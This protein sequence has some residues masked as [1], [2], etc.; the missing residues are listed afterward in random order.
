MTTPRPYT[1]PYLAGIGLGLVLL[2]A[3]VVA[4]RGLGATGAFATA[5][6][7]GVAAAAPEH[8]AA[9]SAYASYSGRAGAAFTGEWLVWQI[10][11]VLLGG[12]LSALA[13]GR[14]RVAV[15]RGSGIQPRGRM[16][17]AFGGG[18]LMGVGAMLARGCT[19]GLA[20]TGGAVLSVGAWIFVACAFAAGYALAP[21][22]RTVWRPAVPTVG[23]AT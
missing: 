21:M 20:L 12:F 11:G 8:A 17:Q 3:F 23:G 2:A 9:H 1:S 10:L 5:V 6:G 18:A 16:L 13:A 19:S 7:S 14:L 22:M 15:E 4:G